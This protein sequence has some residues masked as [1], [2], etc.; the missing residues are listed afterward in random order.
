MAISLDPGICEPDPYRYDHHQRTLIAMK[1]T[2]VL[3][4]FVSADSIALGRLVTNIDDP[5][6]NFFHHD[7]VNSFTIPSDFTITS[8]KGYKNVVSEGF[9]SR[10]E[11]LLARLFTAGLYAGSEK[12]ISLDTK[13][14]C[15]YELQNSDAK[16]EQMMAEEDARKWFEKVL[17]RGRNPYMIVGYQ[18][19]FDASVRTEEGRAG[20]AHGSAAVPEAVGGVEVGVSSSTDRTVKRGT[21]R[22]AEH[23][24]VYAVQYRKVGYSFLSKKD[25][26]NAEL[27]QKTR[28]RVL[29]R[30]RAPGDELEEDEVLEVSTEDLDLDLG[31][32]FECDLDEGVGEKLYF[33]PL[34]S[35]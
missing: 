12:Q 28:W 10:V 24:Q 35:L 4:H 5:A 23:E 16:F 32:G 11:T 31:S 17:K 2:F 20:E 30:G 19:I 14:V 26:E 9:H 8:Q 18:S 6:Q 15:T 7:M 22:V 33:R 34:E 1:S 13:R 21:D 27:R 25:L 3:Q 29:W